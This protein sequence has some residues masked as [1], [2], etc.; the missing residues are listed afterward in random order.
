MTRVRILIITGIAVPVVGVL[1]GLVTGPASSENHW[2]G[3]FNLLRSH[4][5]PSLLFLT[6]VAVGLASLATLPEKRE[7]SLAD[8]SDKLADAVEVDWT[9]E[10]QWRR[11]FDPYPLRVKWVPAD[12]TLV[13]PWASLIELAE[14]RPGKSSE[15]KP[16]LTTGP[17]RLANKKGAIAGLLGQVPT[18]RLVVLGDKGTGKTILLVRLVLDLLS[19]RQP[20]DPVP[21][22]LPLA[23]WNPIE[24]DLQTWIINWLITDRSGL[25]GL[26]SVGKRVTLAKALVEAGR[27]IPVLDG[28]D[29]IPEKVRGTTIAKINDW[30]KP[31]QGLILA[32]RTHEYRTAV[33]PSG[34]APVLL[35]GAA[36]IE[37]QPLSVREVT[38]YLKDSDGAG[39]T[40]GRWDSL[41]EAFMSDHPPPAAR[42]LNTPL[43]AALAR[44]AYNPRPGE[45]VAAISLSPSELLDLIRFPD[46]KAIEDHL[47]DRFVAESYRRHPDSDHPSRRYHWRPEQAQRW[48]T[49]IAQNLEYR[50]DGSTDIAWWRFPTAAPKL[51]VGAV[52]GVIVATVSGIGYSYEGFGFGI[53]MG[54]L[55]G[56]AARQW[57]PAGKTGL[58]SGLAGGVAGGLVSSLISLTVIYQGSA[59]DVPRLLPGGMAIGICMSVMAG[60]IPSFMAAFAGGL[61]VNFYEND[62]MFAYIRNSVGSFKHL[63]NAIGFFLLALLFVK[64]LARNAPTK[65]IHWSPTLLSYGLFGAIV[66]IV[67]ALLQAGLAAAIAVGIAGIVAAGLLAWFGDSVTTDL[68]GATNPE[69]VLKRDRTAFIVSCLGLGIALGITVGLSTTVGIGPNG[70]PLG[71]QFG[72]RTG[73]TAAIIAGL[74]FGFI[75]STWASFVTVRFYL[76]LT[77]R[78]PWRLITFLKD[79]H[80]SRGVLRQVGAVYQFRHVE[81]QRRLA[82]SVTAGYDKSPRRGKSLWSG[83]RLTLTTWLKGSSRSLTQAL[84]SALRRI[85][86]DAERRG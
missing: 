60:V 13:V 10:V 79:A 56:I 54:I 85:R 17:A 65:G 61:A 44:V 32:A 75:Q 68:E 24:Q 43:M 74:I 41:I 72:T 45:N 42:A 27:I 35:T 5:W 19:R 58:V 4:P 78:L 15:E 1:I 46:V 21:I 16:G 48:L 82:R 57:L 25:A 12:P 37:L 11:I 55:V 64:I 6:A 9:Y 51:L 39:G 34:G 77:R 7:L 73:L 53:V 67:L 59:G 36:G 71:P 50:Q 14:S 31:G 62:I 22:L 29:E 63:L 40:S 18:G 76:A 30:M 26:A 8:A 47:Y 80:S 81:V 84:G 49:Y 52:L 2:P 70:H 28:L 66:I 83:G 20:G 38:K 69:T 33:H 3:W 23:S 86:T